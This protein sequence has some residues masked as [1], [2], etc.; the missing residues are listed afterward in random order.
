MDI[1]K[2]TIVMTKEDAGG[3]KVLERDERERYM[4]EKEKGESRAVCG[5]GSE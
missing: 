4:L 5:R 2:N 3:V 1:E